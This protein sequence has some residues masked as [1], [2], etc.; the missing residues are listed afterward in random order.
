MQLG[1]CG[2]SFRAGSIVEFDEANNV[3]VING[4]GFDDTRDYDIL[5]NHG[6]IEPYTKELADQ[7]A[8]AV[9]PVAANPQRG[10]P[11]VQSDEDEMAGTIPLGAS[12]I[13]NRARAEINVRR[14]Q[15][16]RTA[17]ER[18]NQPLPIE[19]Y[20]QTPQERQQQHQQQTH[21]ITTAADVER[22][23]EDQHERIARLMD[24]ADRKNDLKHIVRDDSLGNA[25]SG[26]GSSRNAGMTTGRKRL[27]GNDIA[28][29]R[30]QA[31]RVIDTRNEI[32]RK[33]GLEPLSEEELAKTIPGTPVGMPIELDENL[34]PVEN[35]TEDVSAV[36]D[37]AAGLRAHS[38]TLVREE[39]EDGSIAGQ[40]DITRIPVSE[41]DVSSFISA[42]AA[43]KQQADTNAA[44]PK[45]AKKAIK[46]SGIKE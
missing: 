15:A 9:R 11:V 28:Q 36:D 26:R 23:I 25:V 27:S 30:Q 6:W 17:E 2:D 20:D 4:R 1:H 13:K 44:A 29:I 35:E 22:K 46:K 24:P 12:P 45:K 38:K 19:V 8:I 10:L 32:R 7:Y 31:P 40:E 42:L 16:H 5:L 41:S 14:Q 18:R 34:Q 33:Q 3:L 43:M 37:L 21:R 39:K